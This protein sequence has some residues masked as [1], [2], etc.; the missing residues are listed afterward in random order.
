LQLNIERDRHLPLVR[1]FIGREEPDVVFLEEV[2]VSDAHEWAEQFGLHLSFAPMTYTPRTL[3]ARA[4]ELEVEG[5]AIL[6][7][8]APERTVTE[9][10]FGDEHS[11]PVH[12][13]DDRDSVY[14]PLL[15]VAVPY[16]GTS[17]MLAVTHYMKSWNGAPDEYQRAHMESFLPALMRLSPDVLCGDFN[18]PRGTELYHVLRE[19]LRDNVPLGYTNSLDPHLHRV[20]GLTFMIDYV[21]SSPRVEARNVTQVCGVSDHCAF[22]GEVV[23][24]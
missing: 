1:E 6:T 20:P 17:L 21:W 15:G 22:V 14:Q 11:V 3:G 7:R 2:L 10:Y 16:Q 9:W 23:L 19:H 18:I 5:V 12:V 8:A 24:L 13:E 4:G